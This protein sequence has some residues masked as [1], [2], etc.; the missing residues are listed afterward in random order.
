MANSEIC[1]LTATELAHRIRAKDISTREVVEAHLAQIDRINP[2][3]NAVI[4]LHPQQAVDAGK[5]ADETLVRGQEVGPL[6]GLPI[7]HIRLGSDARNANN[8]GLSNL[9]RFCAGS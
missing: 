2:L 1:F 3:V 4:T 8:D 9:Q 5:A 7:A 6:H